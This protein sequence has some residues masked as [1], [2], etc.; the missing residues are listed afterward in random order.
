[1]LKRLLESL[2]QNLTTII[3]NK[4]LKFEGKIEENINRGL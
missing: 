3:F 4:F 1:M 2:D